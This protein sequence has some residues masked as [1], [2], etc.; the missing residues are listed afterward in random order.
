MA[1]GS[2][3]PQ[4]GGVRHRAPS[5]CKDLPAPRPLLLGEHLLKGGGLEG[6]IL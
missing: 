1:A 2:P 5:R 3:G 6:K 4:S